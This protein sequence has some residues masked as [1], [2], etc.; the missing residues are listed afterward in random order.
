MMIGPGMLVF[1]VIGPGILVNLTLR[2]LKTPKLDC[3]KSFVKYV[4]SNIK[5]LFT[6][7]WKHDI[8][9]LYPKLRT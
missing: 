1:L 7:K 6:N 8:S 4:E 3:T 2:L 9:G 5:A